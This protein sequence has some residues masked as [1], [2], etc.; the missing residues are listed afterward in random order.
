M[1]KRFYVLMISMAVAC[2][3]RLAEQSAGRASRGRA[4]STP[5]RH[6][7]ITLTNDKI[8]INGGDI[9]GMEG[10]EWHEMDWRWMDGQME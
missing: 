8:L 3:E 5:S 10:K 7:Q 2:K 4:L 9:E 1:D 6:H